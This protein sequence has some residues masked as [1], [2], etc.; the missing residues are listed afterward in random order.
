MSSEHSGIYLWFI[1]FG[2]MF[3]ISS[4]DKSVDPQTKE[5]DLSKITATG[6]QG[7]DNFIGTIDLSD[8]DPSSYKSIVF[9]KSFWIQKYSSNDTLFFGGYSA[10]DTIDQSLKVYNWEN[11]SLSIKLHSNNPHFSTPDSAVFQ[12]LTLGSITIS[13]ILPDTANTVYNDI[14]TLKYSAQDS[15]VLKI[16]GYR[17]S[18]GSGTVV[19]S[20]PNYFSLA[21]A[22]PNPTDGQITFVFTV[23]QTIDAALKIV[24]NRNEVVALVAQGNYRGG[25]H[26]ISWNANLEN[27]NYRVL[28]EAGNYTSQGDIR[29]LK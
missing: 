16:K 17:V 6:T 15:L 27:G 25:A 8:W 13:F 11:T 19:V 3:S 5:L 9:G 21:P 14:I 7:P 10:G 18:I 1:A 23:P 2:M 28:F 12:P 4:C 22:Y 20:L 26:S 24:N 29:V